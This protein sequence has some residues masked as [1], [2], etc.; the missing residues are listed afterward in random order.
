M[1]VWLDYFSVLDSKDNMITTL[2]TVFNI[3]YI[4]IPS[5]TIVML[6]SYYCLCFPLYKNCEFDINFIAMDMCMGITHSTLLVI[7]G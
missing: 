4:V 5:F 3:T 2:Y 6:V 1:I 7:F